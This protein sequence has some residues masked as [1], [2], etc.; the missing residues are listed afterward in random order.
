[1]LYH[2]GRF[3]QSFN[4]QPYS[5]R[6]MSASS[7]KAVRFSMNT[8]GVLVPALGEDRVADLPAEGV[9]VQ[10]LQDRSRRAG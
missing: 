6:F 5:G 7:G 9:L 1:M 8:C 3:I 4:Y 2:S 10:K